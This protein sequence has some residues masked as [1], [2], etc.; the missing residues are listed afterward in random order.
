MTKDFQ[1]ERVLDTINIYTLDTVYDFII[2]SLIHHS[3]WCSY[4]MWSNVLTRCKILKAIFKLHLRVLAF[5]IGRKKSDSYHK[6]VVKFGKW[7]VPAVNLSSTCLSFFIA[8]VR[9]ALEFLCVLVI[10][11][12]RLILRNHKAL[13]NI[14]FHLNSFTLGAPLIQYMLLSRYVCEQ[15]NIISKTSFAVKHSIFCSESAITSIK[16]TRLIQYEVN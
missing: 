14:Y 15:S 11:L 2:L 16:N 13:L 10:Y 12:L 3:N 1:I 8:I 5:L 7:H 9:V 6:C 4:K